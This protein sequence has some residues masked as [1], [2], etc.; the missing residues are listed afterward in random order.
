MI[1]FLTIIMLLAAVPGWAFDA[2]TRRFTLTTGTTGLQAFDFSAS[3]FS[4]NCTAVPCA[5]VF[6]VTRAV[7]EDTQAAGAMLSIGFTDGLNQVV[8]LAF[9]DNG[10]ATS[11][12]RRDMRDDRVIQTNTT[13]G[14]SGIGMFYDWTSTGLRI[15]ITDDFPSAYYVTIAIMGGAGFSANAGTFTSN[16]AIDGTTDVN[17]VGFQP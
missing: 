17:T 8:T 7:T 2:A 14:I 5:A 11:H 1:L 4:E 6:I 3:G 13:A 16:A 12:G 10:V 15:D 9:D